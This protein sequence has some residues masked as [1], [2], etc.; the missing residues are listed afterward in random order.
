[1]R[2]IPLEQNKRQK[3]IIL[4]YHRVA[5]PSKTPLLNPRLVSALPN[6]FDAQMEFLATNYNVISMETAL[7]SIDNDV[8]L[9]SRAV[10]ITFDDAYFDFPDFAWPILK[11][12]SLCASV[13]VPTDFAAQPNCGFWWDRLHAAVIQT[14]V[15]QLVTP[16]MGT[17]ALDN[18][19]NR[20]LVLRNL[21]NYIKTLVHQEAMGF[22]GEICRKLGVCGIVQQ[23]T[24]DWEQLKILSKH[25]LILGAHTRTHPLLT[26]VPL[27]KAREE[28]RGSYQDL[29]TN[30]GNVLPIFAYPNG[31]QNDDIRNLL[32]EE[33]IV[34][35][36]AGLQKINDM[37]TADPLALG[38]I[39]I[40]RRTSP[41]LFKFRLYQWFCYIDGWRRRVR[42]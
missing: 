19:K 30:I 8:A 16:T 28:V 12:H 42:F 27:D 3:L 36:C 15:K 10:L 26:Q 18:L 7:E 23:S 29:K 21:Q 13:F 1:M 35:A 25:G 34:M 14:D 22:V 11:K 20:L 32:R 5:D 4:T 39:N 24:M 31:N 6:D 9:P 2:S 17:L 33:G 38:R 40:T 41:L 37:T